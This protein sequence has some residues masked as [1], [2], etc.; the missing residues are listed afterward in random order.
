MRPKFAEFKR[1][2]DVIY[3]FTKRL[4]ISA[5]RVVCYP[6]LP[7]L[8]RKI[9][10]SENKGDEYGEGFG[11]VQ[12]DNCNTTNTLINLINILDRINPCVFFSFFFFFA[13][14]ECID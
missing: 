5:A 6:D 7:K 8:S 12:I 2:G 13:E 11:Q 9:D 14:P 10:A 1:K 4:C 3:L